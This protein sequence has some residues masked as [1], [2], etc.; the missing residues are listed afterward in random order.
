MVKEE[1]DYIASSRELKRPRRCVC[2]LTFDD[3]PDGAGIGKDVEDELWRILLAVHCKER[4]RVARYVGLR[5][6]GFRLVLKRG[7]SL[8]PAQ[9]SSR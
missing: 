3:V 2:C 1:T 9:S 5:R 6:P 7:A 8:R 4:W